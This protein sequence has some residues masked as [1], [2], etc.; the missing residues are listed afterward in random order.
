VIEFTDWVGSERVLAFGP[1]PP[2]ESASPAR[3]ACP[4]TASAP[5]LRLD[6][7]Y[8]AVLEELCRAWR[9]AGE[10]SRLPTSAQVADR[11]NRR[12]LRLTRRAVDHHVEHLVDRLGLRERIPEKAQRGR[13]EAL[14]RE[15]LRLNLLAPGAG[16]WHPQS[17]GPAP[18]TG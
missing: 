9:S 7:A 5:R 3:T 15:A 13:R 12:G 14:V 8:Y 18:G 4:A 11:L 16:A 17:R 1:E 10:G 6:S 2:K